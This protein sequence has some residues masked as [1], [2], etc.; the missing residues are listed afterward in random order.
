MRFSCGGRPSS[1]NRDA[2]VALPDS[3]DGGGVSARFTSG[4]RSSHRSTQVATSFAPCLIK[5]LCPQE[6]LLVTFP[7]TA[8]TSRFCSRAQRAVMP[9]PGQRSAAP[10]PLQQLRQDPRLFQGTRSANGGEPTIRPD[11]RATWL[12]FILR[13]LFIVPHSSPGA[14]HG[15]EVVI[16]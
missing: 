8:N 12:Q 7:G 9:D 2:E 11:Q 16:K 5:V 1:G 10:R 15:K 3:G 4:G 13:E 6:F 14:G